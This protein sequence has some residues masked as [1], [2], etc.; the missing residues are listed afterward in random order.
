M[1]GRALLHLLQ[2]PITRPPTQLPD[3]QTTRQKTNDR[4][5]PTIEEPTTMMMAQ[6]PQAKRRREL[7][8]VDE[9]YMTAKEVQR[10]SGQ[11]IL[12]TSTEDRRF[13]EYFGVGVHV[14]IITWTL[15]S[16]YDLLPEMA[17]VSH[18]LW[19]MYFLKCYPK[20][21]EACA[22]AAGEKGAIDPKT[23][24]KYIWPMIYALSDLES[25]VVSLI[26]Y[27]SFIKY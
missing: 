3:D 5:N 17:I 15:L 20:Q 21:E 1:S 23:W 22:A 11:K 16:E 10:R 13:R 26:F 2:R 6:Q 8:T 4:L 24:R 27:C 25:A 19:A 7:T 9:F 14:G 18:L 12:A